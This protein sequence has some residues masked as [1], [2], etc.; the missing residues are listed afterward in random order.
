MEAK[1][2]HSFLRL[3]YNLKKTKRTGWVHHNVE[4]PESIADH[5]FGI[6]LLALVVPAD[7]DKTRYFIYFTLSFGDDV[8]FTFRCIKMALVHDLGECIVGDYTPGQVSDE[9]KFQE[10]QV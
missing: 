2:I 6:T 9:Q 3:C 4:L 10:E 1:A 5:L 8:L 7:L